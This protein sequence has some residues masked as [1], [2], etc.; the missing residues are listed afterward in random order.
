MSF[1]SSDLSMLTVK[2]G[3]VY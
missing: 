3:L 1:L 2:L